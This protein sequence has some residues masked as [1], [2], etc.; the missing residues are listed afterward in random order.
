MPKKQ[1]SSKQSA[2]SASK[3]ITQ[4]HDYFFKKVMGNPLAVAEFLKEYFP[5]IANKV[6]PGSLTPVD[7]TLISPDLQEK[8]TDLIYHATFQE[9]PGYLY[10]LLEHQSSPDYLMP[11]RLMEY[12]LQII[13]RDLTLQGKKKKKIFPI[14][15]P[16]VIYNGKKPYPY[17]TSFCEMFADPQFV[18]EIITNPFRLIDL[19]KTPDE[20]LS[21]LPLIGFMHMLLKHAAERDVVTLIRKLS[22]MIKLLENANQLDLLEAGVYYLVATNQSDASFNNIFHEFQ[23]HITPSTQEHVMTIAEKLIQEGKQKGR[24]EAMTIAEKLI[25]EGKQKGRQEGR[26]EGQKEGEL[27]LLLRLLKRRF[28]IEAIEPYLKRIHQANCDQLSKWGENLMDAVRVEDV[29]FLN[30]H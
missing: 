5:A 3:A 28:G 1:D 19:A 17:T 27:T 14:V 2:S 11:L 16:C 8:R 4:P 24:Q 9:K 7:G 23:Q 10:F 13:R 21:K 26:Q 6:D 30:S 22:S 20:E 18:Q 25:Q 15:Y 29:F 12:F